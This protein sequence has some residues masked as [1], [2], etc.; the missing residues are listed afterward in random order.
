[1]S[2]ARCA[3]P[4]LVASDFNTLEA[5]Y[6]SLQEAAEVLGVLLPHERVAE[7]EESE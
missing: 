3:T 5:A 2:Q 7:S 1:M 4:A 6:D